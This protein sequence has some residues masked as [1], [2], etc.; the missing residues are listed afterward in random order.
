LDK[1]GVLSEVYRI[2]REK[3]TLVLFFSLNLAKK[4]LFFRFFVKNC[5]TPGSQTGNSVL[6]LIG[7]GLSFLPKKGMFPDWERLSVF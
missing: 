7:E 4:T 5:L 2:F 6:R 3:A 1:T